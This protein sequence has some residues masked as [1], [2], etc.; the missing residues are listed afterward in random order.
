LSGRLRVSVATPSARANKRS[1]AIAAS[2][3]IPQQSRRWRRSGQVDV[4]SG[5]G[6]AFVREAIGA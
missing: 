3:M 4:H 6:T 5:G 2:R 1:S